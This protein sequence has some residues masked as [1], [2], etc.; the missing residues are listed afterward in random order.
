MVSQG[1]RKI[2]GTKCEG[3]VDLG[4]VL[5]KCSSLGVNNYF[6]FCLVIILLA[7]VLISQN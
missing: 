7:L 5:V 2:E 6:V 4:Y 3:G 1:Y